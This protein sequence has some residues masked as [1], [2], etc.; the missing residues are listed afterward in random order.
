MPEHQIDLKSLLVEKP[1]CDAGTVEKLGS[2]L[3]QGKTQYRS[4]REAAEALKKKVEAN[5][6]TPVG[7]RWYLKLGIAQYFIGHITDAKRKRFPS[8]RRSPKKPDEA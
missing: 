6:G 2:G 1:D 5:A 3:A 7:K 4:L 8:P